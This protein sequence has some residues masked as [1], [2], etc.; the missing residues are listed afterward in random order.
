MNAT[1]RTP[2]PVAS[3]AAKKTW[4][5]S[6]PEN[7]RVLLLD[8]D[9]DIRHILLRLLAAEDCCA[10]SPAAATKYDVVLLD[11]NVPDENSRKVFNQIKAADPDFPVV[12]ITSQHGRFFTALAS[13]LGV[14]MEKPLEFVKLLE[15]IR[16]LLEAPAKRPVTRLNE[17]C[18]TPSHIPGEG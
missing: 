12:V 17:M 15:T 10:A 1:V 3:A 2:L 13:G 6:S 8:D 7:Q 4:R 18:L 16:N 5:I 11:L 14:L 9:P